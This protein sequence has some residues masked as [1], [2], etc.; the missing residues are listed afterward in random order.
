[1]DAHQ[2][3]HPDGVHGA[4]EGNANGLGYLVVIGSGLFI[5]WQSKVGK[6]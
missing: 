6:K 1:M 4:D 5:G 2:P 3:L